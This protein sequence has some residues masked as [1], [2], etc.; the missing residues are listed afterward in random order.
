M[1]SKYF[2]VS[3]LIAFIALQ[4]LG[5]Q[6]YTPAQA[7]AIINETTSFVNT[8]NESGYIIFY[9]RLS[10]AYSYLSNATKIYNTSPDL[11]VSFSIKAREIATEEENRI[12]SYAYIAFVAMLIFTLSMLFLLYI[13]MKPIK[14]ARKGIIH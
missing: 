7:R 8:I 10:G 1:Q 11:A 4:S 13:Y 6:N 9:P 2:L 3:I 12:E 5:L 14:K